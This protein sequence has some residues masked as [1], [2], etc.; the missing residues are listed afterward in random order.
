M[1]TLKHELTRQRRLNINTID[2]LINTRAY[3]INLIGSKSDSYINYK[4]RLNKELYK[5]I[6]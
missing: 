1:H 6:K 3:L 5:S 2:I 4:I